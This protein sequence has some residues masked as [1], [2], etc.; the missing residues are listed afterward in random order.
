MTNPL[1]KMS[2]ALFSP[3]GLVGPPRFPT[4]TSQGKQYSRLRYGALTVPRE[5]V[6]I[7]APPPDHPVWAVLMETGHPNLTETLV[8]VSDGSSSVYMSNGDE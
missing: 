5:Q 4:D 6:G 8:L 3:G 2:S 1:K 7:P